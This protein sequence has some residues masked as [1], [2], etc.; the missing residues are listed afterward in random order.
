MEG[1]SGGVPE[2]AQAPVLG[3]TKS[4]WELH[5]KFGE[6]LQKG[7][8]D[9]FCGVLGT[10]L[11][12]SPNP[13][14][15]KVKK[16]YSTIPENMFAA[17]FHELFALHH[18]L[19]RLSPVHAR[20]LSG[21]VVRHK[22]SRSL[23]IV[24]CYYQKD[25][26]KQVWMIPHN[27]TLPASTADIVGDEKVLRKITLPKVSGCLI[28]YELVSLTEPIHAKTVADELER[29]PKRLKRGEGKG[30]GKGKGKG[31][32]P[33]TPEDGSSASDA[34]PDP[35]AVREDAATL[36]DT[37]PA[38]PKKKARSGDA[39][40]GSADGSA[41]SATSG[42]HHGT[43]SH[44]APMVL[45]ET[46][47]KFLRDAEDFHACIVVANLDEKDARAL[48]AALKERLATGRV[49]GSLRDDPQII[50][51]EK[52]MKQISHLRYGTRSRALQE[53][54]TVDEKEYAMEKGFTEYLNTYYEFEEE[55]IAQPEG[56]V[57]SGSRRHKRLLTSK[58]ADFENRPV[59]PYRT[60]RFE[61]PDKGPDS[62][63]S[64]RPLLILI[65][66]KSVSN[67]WEKWL[68]KLQ[69]PKQDFR[70][71]WLVDPRV[72]RD[73]P[74]NQRA[75]GC[76]EPFDV[77]SRGTS[78][79][80]IEEVIEIEGVLDDE[81][82]DRLCTVDLK[83]ACVMCDE[84]IRTRLLWKKGDS[85]GTLQ[86]LIQPPLCEVIRSDYVLHNQ[87]AERQQWTNRQREKIR[88][89]IEVY[90]RA[91]PNNP[92][93]GPRVGLP[94]QLNQH[95]Q[96]AT[97]VDVPDTVY[98]FFVP[99]VLALMCSNN[100]RLEHGAGCRCCG[101]NIRNPFK[102]PL[103]EDAIHNCTTESFRRL[104]TTI[105]RYFLGGL[106][107]CYPLCITYKNVR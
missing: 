107:S 83:E 85:R 13:T 18:E 4:F 93:K 74:A 19:G 51:H 103:Y 106:C 96:V 30:T 7:T 97:K 80:F 101:L 63:E 73:L 71:A 31:R 45:S 67:H 104:K 50:E 25:S 100:M 14:L 21:L 2:Q 1:S 92:L 79:F 62:P 57:R 72:W 26:L 41:A 59:N 15:K 86:D 84:A 22:I 17:I 28:N 27:A 75:F 95:L 76:L 82:M 99:F 98:T 38:R 20:L 29:A 3:K 65:M 40:E 39:T 94:E 24:V 35:D 56:V 52:V 36:D 91:H 37:L 70:V 78:S 53:M 90:N 33:A 42:S 54:I 47:K 11:A 46:D 60:L 88:K 77:K 61:D 12:S 10:M 87:K 89:D 68:P 58:R 44:A 43:R 5:E 34:E 102:D 105:P 9:S 49:D 32:K 48:A 16:C 55:R 64:T 23:Y 8:L 69:K 6:K 81:F 66:K